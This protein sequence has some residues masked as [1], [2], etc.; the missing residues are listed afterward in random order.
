MNDLPFNTTPR[1]VDIVQ[2]RFKKH[3]ELTLDEVLNDPEIE[4]VTV[5]VPNNE[6]VPMAIRRAKKGKTMHPVRLSF[7]RKMQTFTSRVKPFSGLFFM[8]SEMFSEE[9]A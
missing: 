6:L 7:H 9:T 1:D 5:E 3:K 4:A 8:S 2:D